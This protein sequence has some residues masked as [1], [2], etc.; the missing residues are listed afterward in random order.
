MSQ[1][2]LTGRVALVTGGN[3]G[4]GLAIANGL[5][6]SGASI[7]IGARDRAKA[8]A[9]MEELSGRGINA[10]F[11]PLDVTDQDQCTAAVEATVAAFGRIDILANNAG[12]TVRKQPEEFT[13]EEWNRVIATNLTGGFL[14]TQ[15]AFPHM[16]AQ[17]GGKIINVGS[18]HSIFGAS[19]T[20]AYAA[21]KGGIVQLTKT[22]AVAW[23]KHN[24][25]VNAILPGYIESELLE[26]ARA[27][28]DDLEERVFGRTPAGRF[29]TPDELAGAV[30]FLASD[31]SNFVTGSSVVIDGGYSVMG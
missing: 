25:Q 9:A 30:T 14:C 29:G 12:I 11:T 21:S 7:M 27:Q 17:G 23:A 26:K 5:G 4:I 20:A 13:L 6:G 10:R 16:K 19:H 1:F 18:M 8:D 31:A 24:I 22:I 15:A 3:R 2:D 28:V